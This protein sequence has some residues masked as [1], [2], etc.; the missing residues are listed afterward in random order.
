MLINKPT[1][2]VAIAD[3]NNLECTFNM[4]GTLTLEGHGIVY[5]NITGRDRS[6]GNNFGD[7]S[8]IDG[9]DELGKA[10][11]LDYEVD[12]IYYFVFP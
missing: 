8:T 9:K 2:K 4:N 6:G 7:F 12:G 3:S 1:L 5:S 11:I 10:G